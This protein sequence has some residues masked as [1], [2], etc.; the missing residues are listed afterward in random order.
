MTDDDY[1]IRLLVVAERCLIEFPSRELDGEIY[2]ALHGLTDFN[3][4]STPN[5]RD[6]NSTGHILVEQHRGVDVGWF[7]APAYTENK[8]DCST[9]F[10]RHVDIVP[11]NLSVACAAAL[12]AR[13]DA[14][15]SPP[16]MPVVKFGG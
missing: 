14:Q 3:D 15:A 16:Q 12:R 10:P 13:V 8:E 6:A 1:F 5:L 9:L 2:C 11:D 7:K 4:L